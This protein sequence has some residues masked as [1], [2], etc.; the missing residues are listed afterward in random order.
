MAPVRDSVNPICFDSL[1]S[2]RQRSETPKRTL[3]TPRGKPRGMHSLA[4]S[5]HPGGGFDSR[6][7]QN[8]FSRILYGNLTVV[9]PFPPRFI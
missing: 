6:R 5:T 9:V 3:V 1:R 7:P 4:G 8:G 2:L